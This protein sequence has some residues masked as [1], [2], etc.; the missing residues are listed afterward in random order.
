M[1]MDGSPTG[2]PLA[3][4]P[5]G[6]QFALPRGAVGR[7]FG[8]VMAFFNADMERAVVDQ[9]RLTG[10]EHV[11]EIGFGPGVGIACLAELLPAG[12]VAGVDPS[13]VM[14][15]QARR[16]CRSAVAEGR[17]ELRV[18]CAASLPWP[19]N[20]FDKVCAVNNVQLWDAVE[21]DLGEVRRVLKDGGDIVIAVHAWAAKE[22]VLAGAAPG[23]PLGEALPSILAGVGF[24]GVR[25][26][27]ARAR[28][29]DAL[30]FAARR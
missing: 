28:S 8:H 25:A 12:F 18:G 9:L 7:L 27:R 29:G 4:G 19:D 11:L 23:R 3:Y 2:K 24:H 13:E 16:R 6:N 15:E 10:D 26:W 30:Y 21:P 22:A 14:V 20:R 5:V 1:P 17:V